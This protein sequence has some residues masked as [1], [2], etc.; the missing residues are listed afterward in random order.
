MSMCRVFSC[1]VGRG[2]LLWP[3]HFLGKTLLVFLPPSDAYVRSFL[4]LLYTLIKLYYTKALND[5]A[6]SLAPDSILLLQGPRILASLC[7]STIT[8]Q[9]LMM[10]SAYKLNKQDNNIQ[11]WHIP[12]PIRNQSVVPYPVL[13]FA[14][15]PAYRF[16]KRQVRWSGIP[17]SFRIFY[18]LLETINN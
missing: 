8:F 18:S 17:I 15:W 6:S 11:P 5:Q 10:Y 3:V 16:L 14:S 13:T 1:V 9:F 2:C 12:F 7:D 4:Y